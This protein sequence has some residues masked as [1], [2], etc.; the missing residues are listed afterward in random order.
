MGLGHGHL[1]IYVGIVG[2]VAVV[3]AALIVVIIVVDLL[4]VVVAV[5][6][7]GV[8]PLQAHGTMYLYC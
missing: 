1:R 7:V 8:F 2:I 6:V 3:V 5:V 4:M